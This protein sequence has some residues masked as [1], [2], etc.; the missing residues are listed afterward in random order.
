[1]L[2]VLQKAAI[3]AKAGIPVPAFPVRH[4]TDGQQQQ[5]SLDD[6]APM[7]ED[8]GESDAEHARAVA[9]WNH[10]TN[11]LHTTYAMGRADRSLREA[12]REPRMGGSNR[13]PTR[14]SMGS[15]GGQQGRR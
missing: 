9:H 1:V 11:L 7:P 12:D 14:P 10:A 8:E 2:T 6:Q 13:D 15:S 4:A 3:L 5:Q